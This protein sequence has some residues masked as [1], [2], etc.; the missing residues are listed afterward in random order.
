ME[1][2]ALQS[3]AKHRGDGL[4]RGGAVGIHERE[5]FDV[6]VLAQH[7]RGREMCIPAGADGEHRLAGVHQMV[8]HLLRGIRAANHRPDTQREQT[9]TRQTQPRHRRLLLLRL[10]H[11]C[12]CP[13]RRRT[14]LL[15]PSGSPP[16]IVLVAAVAPLGLILL[17]IRG[18]DARH[19][20]VRFLV[21]G[22][23]LRQ[24]VGHIVVVHWAAARC[25]SG[26]PLP[27]RRADRAARR[28]RRGT[29]G[30]GLD[31]RRCRCG[32]RPPPTLCCR[33]RRRRRLRRPRCRWGGGL[34]SRLVTR[35]GVQVAAGGRRRRLWCNLRHRRVGRCGGC[36][37]RGL[38]RCHLRC[39]P[40]GCRLGIR[41]IL[42]DRSRA[43]HGGDLLKVGR[44]EG[45]S[46]GPAGPI[47]H[48]DAIPLGVAQ[49]R[50]DEAEA[51][52]QLGPGLQAVYSDHATQ[53]LGL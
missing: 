51:A 21:F 48:E 22:A 5:D 40:R 36:L 17:R 4:L 12:L 16:P 47:G 43:G 35:G 18:R 19:Q 53:E 33:G 3:Q 38:A 41:C 50:I 52:V 37:R 29:G 27:L 7:P 44:L 42:G 9:L 30:L 32:R 6:G 31:R 24:E 25:R 45:Q 1:H 28:C 49:E 11:L 46:H 10:L 20:V 13:C 14:G 2:H 39:P 34:G 15:L 8:H 26:G 23:E